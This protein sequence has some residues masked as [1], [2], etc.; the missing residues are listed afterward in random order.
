M[1][2]TYTDA[3]GARAYSMPRPKQN[4]H[5]PRRSRRRRV[6]RAQRSSMLLFYARSSTSTSLHMCAHAYSR[7][8]QT[9]THTHTLE[10]TLRNGV[11]VFDGRRRCPQRYATRPSAFDVVVVLSSDSNAIE[12]GRV[13]VSVVFVRVVLMLFVLLRPCWLRVRFESSP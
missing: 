6:H 9:H 8:Q 2:H 3:S 13:F 12:V 11:S 5:E 10:I 7:T 4:T 1:L